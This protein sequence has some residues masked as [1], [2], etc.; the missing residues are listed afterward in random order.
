MLTKQKTNRGGK[1]EQ[2]LNKANEIIAELRN[3]NEKLEEQNKEF[4][5]QLKICRACCKETLR[6]ET[7]INDNWFQSQIDQIDKLIGHE[8]T[9]PYCNRLQYQC[10]KE[11]YLEKNPITCWLD[12]NWGLSCDECWYAAHQESD[13]SEDE[14]DECGKE[15]KEGDH[16]ICCSLES[17]DDS[18]NSQEECS[19]CFVTEK[20]YNKKKG[21][22]SNLSTLHYIGGN[23]YCPDCRDTVN[24]DDEDNLDEMH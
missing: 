20:Q 21:Y 11:T 1:C 15:G 12:D 9:C 17:I 6:G 13:K 2:E 23:T 24:S 10:E 14:Q 8:E 22:I 16:L 19:V 4:Q 5:E 18:E 3:E 7:E